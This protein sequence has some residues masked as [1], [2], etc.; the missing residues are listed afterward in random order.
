MHVTRAPDR[1]SA[2][3]SKEH[4]VRSSL[5]ED[6]RNILPTSFVLLTVFLLS[7]FSL[8]VGKLQT[9]VSFKLAVKS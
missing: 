6:E 3:T 1:Q 2:A 8:A 5:F 9:A 4:R 7:A